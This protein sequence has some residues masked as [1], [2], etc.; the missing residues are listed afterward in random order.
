MLSWYTS[1]ESNLSWNCL[2]LKGTI[3]C[4]LKQST[5]RTKA[6]LILFPSMKLSLLSGQ[7]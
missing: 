7:G 6:E 5:Q 1:V 4:P 3:D 2:Q